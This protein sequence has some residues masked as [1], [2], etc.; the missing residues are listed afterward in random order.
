[1]AKGSGAIA[2][3]TEVADPSEG[4]AD[5]RP[6]QN[7]PVVGGYDCPDQNCQTKHDA[8]KVH[9]TGAGFAMLAKVENEEI[10]ISGKLTLI[11]SRHGIPHGGNSTPKC[12]RLQS[13]RQKTHSRPDPH[14]SH[15]ECAA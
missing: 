11:V 8:A 7:P 1:M 10:V 3:D 5:H 4:V 12:S 2:F 9:V 14:F 6:K 13:P 15:T